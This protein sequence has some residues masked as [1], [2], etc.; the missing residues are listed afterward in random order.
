MATL[1]S[2][3]QAP[4]QLRLQIYIPLGVVS[5]LAHVDGLNAKG[6]SQM[7]GH[8]PPDAGCV[9]V[10]KPK[11]PLIRYQS[12]DQ[13]PSCVLLWK[14]T[15]FD[16]VVPLPDDEHRFIVARSRDINACN[17]MT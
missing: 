11:T 9:D 14:R 6:L 7:L 17:E 5:G 8:V 15:D 10:H 2:R 4:I 1:E 12:C 16:D 13:L 3:A